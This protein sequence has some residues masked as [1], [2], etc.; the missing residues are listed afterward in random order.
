[1]DNMLFR[2]RQGPEEKIRR[3][4]SPSVD[5]RLPTLIRGTSV[6]HIAGEGSNRCENLHKRITLSYCTSRLGFGSERVAEEY[7]LRYFEVGF[8]DEPRVGEI[9]EGR[10]HAES[11]CL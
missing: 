1:M 5:A 9:K 10:P 11:K 2:I 8:R 7:C 3:I 4:V 6:S